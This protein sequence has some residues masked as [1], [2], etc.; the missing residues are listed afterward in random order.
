MQTFLRA[1]PEISAVIL[2]QRL[3]GVIAQETGP[4]LR[5]MDH[6]TISVIAAQSLL[7]SKPQKPEPILEDVF[8]RGLGK[9][10]FDAQPDEPRGSLIGA[11]GKRQQQARQSPRNS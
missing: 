5:A 4:V 10:L 9:A 8:H 3:D 1:D 11:E 2:D 7:R 6:E